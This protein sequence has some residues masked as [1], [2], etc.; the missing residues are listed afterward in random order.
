MLF[1]NVLR[2]FHNR[3]YASMWLYK[4]DSERI[5]KIRLHEPMRC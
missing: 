1:L 3:A 2:P 4:T 5:D